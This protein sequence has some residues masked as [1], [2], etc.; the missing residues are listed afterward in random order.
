[1][2]D[3]ILLVDDEAEIADL[4]ELYLLNEGYQVSKYHDSVH[5]L[6]LIENQ[7]FD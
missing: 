7:E 2:N 1:M 6:T 5:A 4:V 3:K